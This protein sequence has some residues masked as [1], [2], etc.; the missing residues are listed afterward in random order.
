MK[1]RRGY[2]K[3]NGRRERDPARVVDRFVWEWRRG[4]KYAKAV[5]TVNEGG[6]LNVRVSPAEY[7]PHE[8][9]IE[10]AARLTAWLGGCFRHDFD[11]VYCLLW[12]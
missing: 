9:R 1:Q 8:A 11:S 6:G 12:G 2:G 4:T 10:A 7:V 5:A 3:R